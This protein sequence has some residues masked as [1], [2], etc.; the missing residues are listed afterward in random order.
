MPDN[1]DIIKNRNELQSH[2][3]GEKRKILLDI[4]EYALKKIDPENIVPDKVYLKD[5]QTLAA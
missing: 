1:I 5:N 3:D 2:G 4:V